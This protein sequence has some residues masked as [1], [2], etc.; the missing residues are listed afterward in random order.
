[1]FHLKNPFIVSNFWGSP[2]AE[3]KMK[4]KKAALAAA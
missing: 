3:K 2:Q 4:Q 1:V